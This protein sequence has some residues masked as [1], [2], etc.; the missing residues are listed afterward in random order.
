MTDL[1]K[2]SFIINGSLSLLAAVWGVAA[3]L[4][5]R[6]PQKERPPKITGM[7]NSGLV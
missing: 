4:S 3:Y 1:K 2:R 7:S 5:T 6:S